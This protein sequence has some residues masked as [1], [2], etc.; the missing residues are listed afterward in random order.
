MA[1]C[2][3]NLSEIMVVELSEFCECWHQLHVGEFILLHLGSYYLKRSVNSTGLPLHSHLI[4]KN[5]ETYKNST[6]II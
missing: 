1:C 2:S 6:E 5:F 3:V 4:W